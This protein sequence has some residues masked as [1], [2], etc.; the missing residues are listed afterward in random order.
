MGINLITSALRPQSCVRLKLNDSNAYTINVRKYIYIPL[1]LLLGI[2][3]GERGYPLF[4]RTPMLKAMPHID[5]RRTQECVRHCF[6]NKL[7]IFL[8]RGKEHT[9]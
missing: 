9:A 2:Y 7:D 8:L 3:K 5:F 6:L 4:S 1:F